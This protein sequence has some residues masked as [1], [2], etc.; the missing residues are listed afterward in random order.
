MEDQKPLFHDFCAGCKTEVEISE[1][2]W[3]LTDAEGKDLIFCNQKC[4]AEWTLKQ[5]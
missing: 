4:W 1:D 3:L 5:V 2:T